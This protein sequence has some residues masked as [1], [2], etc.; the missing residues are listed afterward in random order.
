MP[1][2]LLPL[3]YPS[4]LRRC[5][6]LWLVTG[7]V[8]SCIIATAVSDNSDNDTSRISR[9]HTTM[10]ITR[11][12]QEDRGSS[13]GT[14][15]STSTSTNITPRARKFAATKAAL[16]S[17]CCS[18]M[19]HVIHQTCFLS[20][21]LSTC[22]DGLRHHTQGSARRSVCANVDEHAIQLLFRS[23]L[24]VFRMCMDSGQSYFSKDILKNTLG[25]KDY[26]KNGL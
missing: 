14:S 3:M 22:H 4:I 5:A 13:S 18:F 20:H 24:D 1:F 2:D 26:Q 10:N 17:T 6:S 21:I 7:Q 19:C 9:N 8:S 16:Q 12:H 11:I 23:F 25:V 15:T